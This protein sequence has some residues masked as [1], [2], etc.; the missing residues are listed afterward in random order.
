[1]SRFIR[2]AL[3]P[4]LIVIIVAMFIEYVISNNN[5]SNAQ[6]KP[7][8]SAPGTA[9]LSVLNSD[10]QNGFIKSVVIDPSNSKAQVTQAGGIQ[11]FVVQGISNPTALEQQIKTGQPQGGGQHRHGHASV[12]SPAELHQR[13]HQRQGRQRRAQRQGPDAGGHAQ[14]GA[15]GKQAQYTVAYTDPVSTTALLDQYNV[16]YDATSPK[17]AWWS[18]ALA[19]IL[20]FIL[21]IGLWIFMMNQ[22]Q[23]GGSKVMSFG[24]SRAKRVSVDS[25]K[26]TFKDVAGAD[27]AVEELHEIKEFLENPKKFQ[28]LGARIPKGVLLFGPP[29][30]GKTLLARAVAGEAGVPFFSIGHLLPPADRVRIADAGEDLK[31]LE[32]PSGACGLIQ[33]RGH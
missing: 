9:S 15:S 28:Q 32:L 14:E 4:I 27:E 7:I 11:Y 21:I 10:L 16:A 29:G 23:G 25:P 19:F 6:A 3:F 33:R 5:K 24:K 2:S 31:V 18:G 13:R 17:S 30:T 22:M 12:D 1:M 26:V 8:Y 20:P